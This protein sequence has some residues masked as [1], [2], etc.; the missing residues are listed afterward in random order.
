M[1]EKEEKLSFAFL[2]AKA[3][4]LFCSVPRAF[5]KHW[6]RNAQHTS[7]IEFYWVTSVSNVRECCFLSAR[8]EMKSARMTISGREWN[9][10]PENCRNRF[11]GDRYR[12]RSGR[13]TSS[14]SVSSSCSYPVPRT[15]FFIIKSY[16]RENKLS[17][18]RKNKKKSPPEPI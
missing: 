15:I 10:L 13:Q 4:T 18:E 9:L 16:F 17:E 7:L 3:W 6:R 11:P 2:S 1:Y 12:C 5:V 8:D 14:F